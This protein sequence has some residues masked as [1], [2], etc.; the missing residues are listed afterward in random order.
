M[1]NDRITAIARQLN[2]LIQRQLDTLEDQ[3]LLHLTEPELRDYDFRFV[4]IKALCHDLE[5]EERLQ[6]QHAPTA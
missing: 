1:A 2:V 6:E 3:N 5:R 4:R